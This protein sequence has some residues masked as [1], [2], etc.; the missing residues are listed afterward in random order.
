MLKLD[1]A[2]TSSDEEAARLILCA[3]VGILPFR[4]EPFNDNPNATA[5]YRKAVAPTRTGRGPDA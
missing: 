2:V 1:G 5:W 4:V 3:D